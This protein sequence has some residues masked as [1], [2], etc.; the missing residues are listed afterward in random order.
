MEPII[1]ENR[2]AFPPRQFKNAKRAR[3]LHHIMGRPTPENLKALIKMNSIKDCP[4]QMEDVDT[5]VKIFGPDIGSLKGKSVRRQ[6]PPVRDN[7][8]Q[9]PTELTQEHKNL[10]LCIDIMFVNSHPLLT[11]IDRSICVR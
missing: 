9:I 2:L 5:A 8:T 7:V 6:P 4:V 11:A 3:R 1:D 10:V